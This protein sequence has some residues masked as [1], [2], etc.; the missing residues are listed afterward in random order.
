M[1][2][3]APVIDPRTAAD[4]ARQLRDLLPQYV[5]ENAELLIKNETGRYDQYTEALIA[6]F[7]RYAEVIIERLNRVPEKN[8]LA[9]LNLL[10]STPLAPQPARVPLTFKLAPG[11]SMVAR[12]PA[13]TQV[14]APPGE[15]EDQP[16]VFETESEL[17][18]TVADLAALRLI[19]P[20]Q[21]KYADHCQLFDP[22]SAVSRYPF[23]ADHRLEHQLYIGHKDLF[24]IIN[25]QSVDLQLKLKQPMGDLGEL[26]WEYWDG[27]NWQEATPDVEPPEHSKD[28][29]QLEGTGNTTTLSFSGIAPLPLHSLKI[30]AKDVESR[31]LRCRL[32]TPITPGTIQRVG[33]VRS[34]Q[35]PV[36]EEWSIT[37]HVLRD[38]MQ[39]LLAELAF[40]NTIPVDASRQF[41]PFG[42]Q[43][44]RYD[45]FYLASSEAFSKS[46]GTVTHIFEID[47]PHHET[48]ATSVWASLDLQLA[49]ETWDEG[50]WHQIGIGQAPNKW[51]SL[52]EIESADGPIAKESNDITETVAVLQGR[53][54]EG[55]DLTITR[56]PSPPRDPVTMLITEADRFAAEVLLVSG[57]NLIYVTAEIRGRT[58]RVVTAVLVGTSNYVLTVTPKLL[59]GEEVEL[60]VGIVSGN[61][62]KIQNIRATNHRNNDQV[63]EPLTGTSVSLT[64]SL[65]YGRNAILIEALGD[66]DRRLAVEV[67]NVGLADPDPLVYTPP[68][69]GESTLTDGTHCLCQ[70]GRVVVEMPSSIEKTVINGQENYWLR[71]RII[72]GHYGKSAEYRLM[73]PL[74][75]GKGYALTPATFRPPL[76]SKLEIGYEQFLNDIPQVG[77]TRNSGRFE[78]AAF[79]QDILDPQLKPFVPVA[80]KWKT[81]HFGFKLPD[82]L[83]SFPNTT[84]RLFASMADYSFAE[85]S[86][87]FA[88]FYS[89]HRG[90]AGALVAHRF[91]VTNPRSEENLFSFEVFGMGID[92]ESDTNWQA[93][94]VPQQ[95]L[96][97]GD[98][99]AEVI[100]EVRI[101]E[102]AVDGDFDQGYLRLIN[103]NFPDERHSAGFLTRVS[104]TAIPGD[105]PDLVWQYWNGEE[106]SNLA[107]SDHTDQLT[108]SGSITFLAPD[109]FSQRA[110]FGQTLYWLRVNWESGRYE[111]EPRLKWLS[112]NTTMASQ[113]LTLRNEVLGSSNG[114][115]D[116]IFKTTRAPVLDGAQLVVREPERPGAE[117]LIKLQK[118]EG[119]GAV[120]EIETG[121]VKASEF[122]VCWHQMPDF[123]TSGPR[124]RHYI[125]DHLTGDIRFGNGENGMIPPVGTGNLRMRRYRTGGGLIGN[126]A[127]GT[128]VQLKT[129][130]PYIESVINP[131]GAAGGAEAESVERFV[132]RAPRSIRHRDRAVTV[133]DYED[134][135]M[136]ASPRVARSK[137]V[138]LYNLALDP[139]A[140]AQQPGIVSVIIVPR[141]DVARPQPTQELTGRVQDYLEQYNLPTAR[142]VVVG[143][144]YIRV[145]VEVEIVVASLDAVGQVVPASEAALNGFLH[146][147]KG[148]ADGKGWD[149]GRTP[150]RSDFY[151]LLEAVPDVK[152]VRTLDWT[153][154]PDREGLEAS[155]RF[156]IYAGTHKISLTFETS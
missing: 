100:V 56:A 143:P 78:T 145:S 39:G 48:G 69:G 75:P 4:I 107:I 79:S 30:G 144:E 53:I 146:P 46:D 152:Y 108:R 85:K 102:G 31:W 16:V 156:L 136:L 141:S 95:V 59:P 3:S 130:L 148:G 93:S 33:M 18:V 67:Q 25:T 35:L 21:D 32:V 65:E 1:A 64:L 133:E 131:D 119:S 12:I 29:A 34:E 150:L 91:R 83:K 94:V 92:E 36:I 20:M 52:V 113:S 151:A 38:A 87:P 90:S 135:A 22:E 10:G 129:T 62:E 44:K 37:T 123:Y 89:V 14:A 66:G 127:A 126:K 47:N 109:D 60:T 99:S 110:Q 155:K 42:E 97:A 80:D 128:V 154:V 142:V 74:D 71:A 68:G 19:D 101:P 114:T 11:S 153:L 51:L 73:D 2:N 118:E 106:W 23:Q 81:L 49:W 9:F 24:G 61:V 115:A 15:G 58:Q 139:D 27:S 17:M 132:E 86:V 55:V 7:S 82:Q 77:Y 120:E 134:L 122:W 147:L 121:T 8:F 70:S 98:A 41:L 112:P 6:I 140:S 137:S 149:F 116:Q 5:N 138:P 26:S 76:V 57:Y 88:P 40:T 111:L 54:Q 43:P 105:H 28:L 63:T 72:R 124:D 50:R 84:V 13:G 104:A 45:T 117:E 96:L 125:L 103:E